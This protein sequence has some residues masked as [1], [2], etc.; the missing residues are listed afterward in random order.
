MP[1]IFPPWHGRFLAFLLT[2]SG[3]SKNSRRRNKKTSKFRN[4]NLKSKYYL[5]MKCSKYFHRQ[6]ITK[7]SHKT[8]MPFG[9]NSHRKWPDRRIISFYSSAKFKMAEWTTFCNSELSFLVQ[10]SNNV[11]TISFAL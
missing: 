8:S 6:E 4:L 1:D 7:I 10:F 9:D 3:L 11:C 5:I 2:K